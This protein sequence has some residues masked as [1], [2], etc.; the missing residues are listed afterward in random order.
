MPLCDALDCVHLHNE[1]LHRGLLSRRGLFGSSHVAG[2]IDPHVSFCRLALTENLC[3][4]HTLLPFTCADDS[5]VF[6]WHAR[7][8]TLLN[9]ADQ[10]FFLS[11]DSGSSLFLFAVY[12]LSAK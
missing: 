3:H 7:G 6:L 2:R 9:F 11:E 10:P 8:P 4:F 12:S 1:G 5:C